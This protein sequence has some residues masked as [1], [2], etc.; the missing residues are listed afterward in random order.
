M[1]HLIIYANPNPQSFC[2]EIVDTLA[3]AIK[4]AGKEVIIKDLYAERFNPVLDMGD[5]AIMDKNDYPADVKDEHELL[6]DASVITFIYPIWWLGAPAIL[7]GYFDRVFAEGFAYSKNEKGLEKGF[8]GKKAVIIN[9]MGAS[10]KVYEREGVLEAI[11]KTI[12]AGI[13]EYTGFEI[14]EHKFFGE[15]D[16]L[17]D[18]AKENILQKVRDLG[19]KLTTTNVISVKTQTTW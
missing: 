2:R 16:C 5:F 1:K 3:Q 18:A 6:Q 14:V 11:K 17:D 15:V 19:E 4:T 9:T 7:K 13:L 12:D 8:T 10:H